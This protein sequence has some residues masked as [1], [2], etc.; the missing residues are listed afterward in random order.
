MCLILCYRYHLYKELLMALTVD[1]A[2]RQVG[3][4]RPW[5]LAVYWFLG[6][7][8][9]IPVAWQSLAIVFIGKIL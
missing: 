9:F 6:F 2:L 7:T 3:G 8:A 5:Q 4:Y 1:E